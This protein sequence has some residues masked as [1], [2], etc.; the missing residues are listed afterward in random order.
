[1]K[2]FVDLTLP[3]KVVK[4]EKVAVKVSV[5][6][7]QQKPVMV[8]YFTVLLCLQLDLMLH[9]LKLETVVEKIVS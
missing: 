8:C 4:N 9:R 5:F 7:Y 6:N 3:F 1:M 2:L